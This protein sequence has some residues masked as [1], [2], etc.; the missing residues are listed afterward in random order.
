MSLFSIPLRTGSQRLTVDLGDGDYN[1]R[2]LYRKAPE[3]GWSMDIDGPRGIAIHGV[4]LLLGTDL[5]WQFQY[6][7]IPGQLF[8]RRLNEGSEVL[9]YDDMGRNIQLLFDNGA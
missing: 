2:F 6:F 7:Q 8:V 4:P 5:L 9:S 1:F 3:T